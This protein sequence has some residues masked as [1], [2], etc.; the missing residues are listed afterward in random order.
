MTSLKYNR[1]K[2][3]LIIIGF[4]QHFKE[5]IADRYQSPVVTISIV[6]NIKNYSNDIFKSITFSLIKIWFAINKIL[7]FVT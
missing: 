6:T 5:G 2:F 1:K 3:A 7:L 4:A